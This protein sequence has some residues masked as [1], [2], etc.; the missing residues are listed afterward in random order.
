[1]QFVC[2]CNVC[3]CGRVGVRGF[4][5]KVSSK[6]N[7]ARDKW[8]RPGVPPTVLLLCDILRF[9]RSSSLPLF[10][11]FFVAAGRVFSPFSAPSRVA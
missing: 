11:S 4:G 9:Y 5:G 6:G 8:R 3:V 10:L 7:A 2:V 1:M